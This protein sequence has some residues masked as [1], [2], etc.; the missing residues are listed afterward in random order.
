MKGERERDSLRS[1][2]KQHVKYGDAKEVLYEL[3]HSK[4]RPSKALADSL[5][6]LIKGNPEFVLI[7]DQKEVYEAALAAGKVATDRQPRVVIIEGGPG[8]GKTVLAINLLVSLTA[9]AGL[10]C[11]YVSINAAPRSVYE[12]KLVRSMTKSKFF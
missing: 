10:D 6:G 8:T 5:K 11:K 1:L 9:A 12:A 4:I 7:D 3:V 2:I